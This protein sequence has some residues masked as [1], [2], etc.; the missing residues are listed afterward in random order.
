MT[1][2]TLALTAALGLAVALA[3]ALLS[4]PLASA[5]LALGSHPEVLDRL[6][7]SLDDQ[8]RLAALDPAR[9][10][11]YRR[12]FEATQA[13]VKRLRVLGYTREQLAARWEA[14][15]AALVALAVGLGGAG[16]SWH[17]A[18]QEARLVRLQGALASLARGEPD[19]RVGE[20]RRDLIGRI[21]AMV[22]ESSRRM[23]RDRRRL[24][25]LENLAAWQEAAR[26]HAHEMRTPLTAA[27]LELTRLEDRLAAA[28]PAEG[29]DGEA[30]RRLAASAMA[31]LDRLGRFAQAFTSFARLP[32]PRIEERDLALDLAEVAAAFAGAWPNLTLRLAEPAAAAGTVGAPGAAGPWR[33]RC[34]PEMLRQAL[35][36]LCDNSS[37]AVGARPGGGTVAFSLGRAGGAVV[38]DVADDGPGVPA[39]VRGRLFEPYQTTRRIGEGMGLGLAIARKMLLDQGGDLELAASSGAGATFRLYLLDAGLDSGPDAGPAVEAAG[40]VGT[41]GAAG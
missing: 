21:A 7:A 18:R 40:G 12:R 28:G 33:V 2:A 34:D 29:A 19:V 8:K 27:K 9:T 4:R 17:Q 22:E 16:Y 39:A 31:E 14:A 10:P 5:W 38:L 32:A 11:L 1:V 24:A 13:V 36:N 25:S 23:A 3:V 6:A 37:L 26:R 35:V 20:R 15:L 30:P 41:V